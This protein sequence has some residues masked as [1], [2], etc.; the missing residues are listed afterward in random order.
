M[1]GFRPH[2]DRDA[3]GGA[4]L[5]AGGTPDPTDSNFVLLDGRRY[6][7]YAPYLLPTDDIEFTR[8]DFEHHLLRQALKSNVLAPIG[9]PQTILDV[10]LGT[11]R[12][13]LEIAAQFPS[14]GVFG[15]DIT[16][17][18]TLQTIARDL[19]MMSGDQAKSPL[20]NFSFVAGN[21][22]TQLPFANG[23]FDY[24]HMRFLNAAVPLARWRHVMSE[25]VRVTRRGGW[26]EAVDTSWTPLQGGPATEQV[27]YWARIAG[28]VREINLQLAVWLGSL[29]L[30]SGLGNVTAPKL[31]FPMGHGGGRIGSMVA[32]NAIAVAEAIQPW[33]VGYNIATQDAYTSALEA[34]RTEVME[35]TCS[36]PLFVSYG[37]RL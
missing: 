35:R 14:A 1:A 12:W 15:L 36:Y 26:I 33:V 29:L 34:L 27:F 22:L 17:P 19:R 6:F 7:A 23:T 9:Q 37:Q 32:A 24:V 18:P 28:M 3:A 31:Q 10:G 30:D 16:A 8:Q 25:L 4:G 5:G 21:I 11:G 20:S 13:A 2:N